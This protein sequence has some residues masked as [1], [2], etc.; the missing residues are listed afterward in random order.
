MTQR[1]C[2]EQGS[3]QQ[4]YRLMQQEEQNRGWSQQAQNQAYNYNNNFWQQVNNYQIPDYFAEKQVNNNQ[5]PD[6]F[7]EQ[8][9]DNHQKNIF[10]QT[11]IFDELQQTNTFDNDPF[12][13]ELLKKQDGS[14]NDISILPN[15][16]IFKSSNPTI[17]Q[18]FT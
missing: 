11:Q 12:V 16:I 5:I 2:W 7:I 3:Y 9:F 4:S 17:K 8:K 18:I 6:Y 15:L 13:T 1:H 10:D 14:W